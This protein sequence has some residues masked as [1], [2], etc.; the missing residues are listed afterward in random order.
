MCTD[1]LEKLTESALTLQ[2]D[3][4]DFKQILTDQTLLQEFPSKRLIKRANT[5]KA[6]LGSALFLVLVYYV[7]IIPDND[8][9]Q[10]VGSSPAHNR[11]YFHDW[12]NEWF[13]IFNLSIHNVIKTVES[14]EDN[15]Q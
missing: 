3:I 9:H 7:P 13:N 1:Q 6:H 15:I 2:L 5:M 11:L 12:F 10:P 4:A 14:I 8:D